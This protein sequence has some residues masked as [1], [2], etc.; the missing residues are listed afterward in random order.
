MYCSA[1]LLKGLELERAAEP[2]P[3]MEVLRYPRKILKF[4]VKICAFL[5]VFGLLFTVS[6]TLHTVANPD[7][8]MVQHR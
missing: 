4:Y 2:L 1:G 8:I 6:V 7:I 3:N 5:H